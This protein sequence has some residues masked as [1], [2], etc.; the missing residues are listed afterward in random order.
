M[1]TIF[2]NIVL[3]LIVAGLSYMN[4]FDVLSSSL[5]WKIALG[6]V[7]VLLLLAVKVLGSPFTRGGNKNDFE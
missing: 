5:A 4:P 6:L 7:I 3:L 2:I 1:K